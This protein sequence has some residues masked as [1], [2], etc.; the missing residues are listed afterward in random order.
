[1]AL[2]GMS[3][4]LTII[5]AAVVILVTALVILTI[6]GQGMIPVGT[7]TDIRNQCTLTNKQLCETTGTVSPTWSLNTFIV[8]GKPWSCKDACDTD[9]PCNVDKQWVG[10]LCK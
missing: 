8:D 5:V 2:K 1:M 10:N 9:K 4:T 6:F 3:M 7:L